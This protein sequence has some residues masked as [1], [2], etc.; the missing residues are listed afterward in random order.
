MASASGGRGGGGGGASQHQAP[1]HQSRLHSPPRRQASCTVLACWSSRRGRKDRRA[2]RRK[3]LHQAVQEAVLAPAQ[4]AARGKSQ[5]AAK[6][7][8]GEGQ[9]VPPC[10]DSTACP[11]H[12]PTPCGWCRPGCA[13]G[14]LRHRAIHHQLHVQTGGA[15][16][17]GLGKP[18]RS[19]KARKP[20]TPGPPWRVG[21][22]L[23]IPGEQT[24]AVSSV[25]AMSRAC[26]SD[27]AGD[28]ARGWVGFAHLSHFHNHKAWRVPFP[29]HFLPGRWR[30]SPPTHRVEAET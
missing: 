19:L 8:G 13:G 10:P 17:R 15:L 21:N 11:V 18:V 20:P 6:G 5:A 23:N 4:P 29:T 28:R 9:P 22:N 12:P 1:L 24:C 14:K 7:P 3:G 25:A 27:R 26:E 2:Q 30:D 16:G